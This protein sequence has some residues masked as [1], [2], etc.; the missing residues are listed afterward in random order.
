MIEYPNSLGVC[1]KN[2][3]HGAIRVMSARALLWMTGLAAGVALAAFIPE[4]VFPGV[5]PAA[6]GA[7][8]LGFGLLAELG[9]RHAFGGAPAVRPRDR[10]PADGRVDLAR[11]SGVLGEPNAFDPRFRRFGGLDPDATAVPPGAFDGATSSPPMLGRVTLFSLFIGRDGRTWTEEELARS[12]EALLRAGAWVEREA[13]RWQ[14]TVNVE[15]A[16][17]YF[18]ADD[19]EA[20]EVVVGFGPEG[21]DVGPL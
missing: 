12:H 5:R 3:G 20:D 14:A 19:D 13:G 1:S 11:V 8:L 18:V 17:T 2:R 16:D 9:L 15:V 10:R 6:F 21:D 7:V 4:D